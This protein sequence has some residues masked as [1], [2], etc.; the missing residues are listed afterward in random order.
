ML[1]VHLLV[2]LSYW[3]S[4][5]KTLTCDNEGCGMLALNLERGRQTEWPTNSERHTERQRERPI[6]ILVTMKQFH[7]LMNTDPSSP[8]WSRQSTAVH[9]LRRIQNCVELLASSWKTN[10]NKKETH[11][12]KTEN[13]PLF[14]SVQWLPI[15]QI[16][17]YDINAP[18]HKSIT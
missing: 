14:Q 18:C 7:N 16:I 3:K 13:I 4:V 17:Q 10:Q 2:R 12:R 6:Y 9:S 8:L 1:L 15:P 5:S 11:T